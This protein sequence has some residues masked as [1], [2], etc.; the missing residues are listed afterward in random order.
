VQVEGEE[1]K[2]VVYCLIETPDRLL[3]L[4]KATSLA[5]T[6]DALVRVK[7]HYPDVDMAKVNDGVEAEKDLAALEHEVQDD[8]MEVMDSL[9]YEGNDGGQ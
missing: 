6:T 1:P 9:D 5:V 7:S 2:F 8:A 3:T 4:L